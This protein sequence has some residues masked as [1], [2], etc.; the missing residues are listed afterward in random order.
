MVNALWVKP[1]DHVVANNDGWSGAA[2][3]GLDQLTDG[4]EIVAHITLFERNASRREVSSRRGARRSTGLTEQK[5][6]SGAFRHKGIRRRNAAAG[7]RIFV[8]GRWSP[9]RGQDV[10]PAPSAPVVRHRFG[11]DQHLEQFGSLLLEADLQGG[12]YVVYT[13]E[14]QRIGQSAM[15]GHI[16]AVAHLL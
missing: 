10:P 8:I 12:G 15:T 2:V 4:T 13:R 11:V 1:D 6:A 16:D 7:C 14:R 9:G 5:N 3:I